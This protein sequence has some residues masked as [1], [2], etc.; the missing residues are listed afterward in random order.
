METVL[1]KI[2]TDKSLTVQEKNWEIFSVLGIK[3]SEVTSLTETD[4]EFLLTKVEGIKEQIKLQ[5]A[6]QGIIQ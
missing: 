2:A 4:R 1:N 5:R 3:W 6:S